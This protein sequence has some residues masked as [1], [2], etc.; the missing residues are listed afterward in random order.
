M[1]VIRG[2]AMFPKCVEKIEMNAFSQRFD[3]IEADIPEGYNRGLCICRLQAAHSHHYPKQCS[4]Q[5]ISF[6]WM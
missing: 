3:L 2:K 6:L 4:C 1:E 5:G